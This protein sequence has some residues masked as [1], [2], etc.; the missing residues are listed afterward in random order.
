M[1]YLYEMLKTLPTRDSIANERKENW[2]LARNRVERCERYKTIF[3]DVDKLTTNH[4][5]KLPVILI[6]KNLTYKLTSRYSQ[7]RSH[8]KKLGKF[9]WKCEF[10]NYTEFLEIVDIIS[11]IRTLFVV[12][13][14]SRFD[15]HNFKFIALYLRK[16]YWKETK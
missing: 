11:G 14:I 7:L 8:K 9:N 2:S 15:V 4:M 5:S 3:Q 13:D 16:K 12:S 6:Y 1:V 10:W